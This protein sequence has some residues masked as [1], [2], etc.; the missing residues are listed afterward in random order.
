MNLTVAT[1]LPE[2]MNKYQI[3]KKIKFNQAMRQSAHNFFMNG[4]IDLITREEIIN[5]IQKDIDKLLGRLNPSLHK[6]N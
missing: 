3:R 5:L 1:K 2:T 4:K 6:T